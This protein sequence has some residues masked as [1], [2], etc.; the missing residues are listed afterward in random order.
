MLQ[1][2]SL[3]HRIA[4]RLLFDGA[5]AAVHAG[6]RVGLVGPNGCGKTTLLKLIAG[7]QQADEG[8]ITVPRRWR[9]GTLA[10]ARTRRRGRK[11]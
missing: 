7:Q 6:A 3:R 9:V 11:A 1:I 10:Q 5:S 4:G 2:T 8:E